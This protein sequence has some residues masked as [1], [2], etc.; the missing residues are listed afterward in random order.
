LQALGFRRSFVIN[1]RREEIRLAQR[2]AEANAQNADLFLAIHHDSV[3]DK[4]LKTWE[5]NGKAQKYCDDFHGYS[6]FFSHKNA[7]ATESFAFASKLGQALL[8]AGFTPTL[9]HVE[10]ENRPIIDTEK[11]IY[12]FDDLVVLKTARMPAVLLE[13]GVIVNRTEEENLNNPAYRKRLVEAICRA[14]QDF[15]SDIAKKN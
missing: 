10:Q 12:A 2:P 6:I 15:S 4:F 11:G 14:I 9:H 5:V 8:N 1:P 7:K 3:K 13:C